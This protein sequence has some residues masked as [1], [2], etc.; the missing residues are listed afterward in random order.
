MKRKLI[1]L[2]LVLAG[3]AV[4]LGFRLKRDY[5]E[6]RERERFMLSQRP[7]PPQAPRIVLGPAS[8]PVSPAQY[9]DVA[10]KM[11]FSQDRSPAV[12][13]DPVI[14][15]KPKPVPPFPVA[16][17]V[18]LFGDLPPTVILS[19]KGKND[20]KGYKVG[21]KVGEFEIASITNT[22]V[23]FTWDD[24]EFTKPI[25]ELVDN[26]PPPSDDTKPAAAGPRPQGA[27]SNSGAAAV[28]ARAAGM[29]ET[30]SVA[31]SPAD[32]GK[33]GAPMGNDFYG[34]NAGDTA[35]A[36]TVVNGLVKREAKNPF[37]PGGKSCYWESSH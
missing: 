12:I 1:L 20:Q 13:L 34:C 22:D 18:I 35:P 17:G 14:P 8:S 26:S 3:L 27:T 23:V 33:P 37:S 19:T 10:Q 28:A 32:A 5:E 6:A 16:R 2:N 9:L 36:G 4:F 24:Q 11:L 31:L 30:K 7:K 21:D 15:P 29:D 25:S